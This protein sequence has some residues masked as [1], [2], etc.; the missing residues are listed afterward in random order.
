MKAIV[1]ALVVGFA[2]G[3]LAEDLPVVEMFDPNKPHAETVDYITNRSGK[4]RRLGKI[5]VLVVTF[6]LEDA[7]PAR[8]L[9]QALARSGY[10]AGQAEAETWHA[11]WTK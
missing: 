7:A 4:V 10:V 2:A 3:A 5:K 8:E 9:G 6:G 1:S 11:A